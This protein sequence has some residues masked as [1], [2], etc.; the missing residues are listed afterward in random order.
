M[1]R[2]CSC[3]SSRAIR[4]FTA[5]LATLGLPLL[6]KVNLEIMSALT[7]HVLGIFDCLW[8]PHRNP[9]R[10]AE[11][12]E[13]SKRLAAMLPL[14]SGCLVAMCA[15]RSTASFRDVALLSNL[16][17]MLVVANECVTF[18]EGVEVY[19]DV[20]EALGSAEEET[21]NTETIAYLVSIVGE[22]A[23][24]YFR[25]RWY[26]RNR[27][28]SALGL[29]Y[30]VPGLPLETSSA[31]RRINNSIMIA[32]CCQSL[33]SITSY[34]ELRSLIYGLPHGSPTLLQYLLFTSKHPAHI[35]L[36]EEVFQP[37]RWL[38]LLEY[39]AGTLSLLVELG[40]LNGKHVPGYGVVNYNSEQRGRLYRF[41]ARI[42]SEYTHP[43]EVNMEGKK[44]KLL[45]LR[46][47]SVELLPDLAINWVGLGYDM[48][49]TT[50]VRLSIHGAEPKEYT[51]LDISAKAVEL[52]SRDSSAWNNLAWD[53]MNDHPDGR[54]GSAVVKGK[55]V[56]PKL[57]VLQALSLDP[58]NSNIWDTVAASIGI[59]GV[60][61]EE[62][63]SSTIMGNTMPDFMLTTVQEAVE[64]N[65]AEGIESNPSGM[66]YSQCLFKC[67]ELDEKPWSG[68]LHLGS[69]LHLKGALSIAL[70]LETLA[71]EIRSQIKSVLQR[72]ENSQ[73]VDVTEVDCYRLALHFDRDATILWVV[74]EERSVL[75]RF[76]EV[77]S[78]FFDAKA[79]RLL[80]KHEVQL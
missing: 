40:R 54:N 64:H 44:M 31:G 17:R 13:D 12:P 76:I 69:Y 52:N 30:A 49:D 61:S 35:H 9:V 46:K 72:S 39:A 23:H 22:K 29:L 53:I 32:G 18:D 16:S 71:V 48:R 77:A 36:R 20:E 56:T 7:A 45:D 19:N 15:C 26:F 50:S 34:P 66:M 24:V 68:F 8:R 21:S 28:S 79:K 70:P 25:Q 57:A 4:G 43:P 42:L 2:S 6:L 51:K 14:E 11:A 75:P 78:P 73:S 63:C 55:V 62:D 38:D 10:E 5:C 80:R 27:R 74:T 3:Q 67:I 58:S 59:D 1:R 41:I 60:V 33:P 37:H 47:A 65:R